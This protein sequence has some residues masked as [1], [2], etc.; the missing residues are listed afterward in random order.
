MAQAEQKG[1]PIEFD[2]LYYAK[3][4]YYY[5]IDNEIGQKEGEYIRA[6]KPALN[7]QIPKAEDWRKFDVK[8]IDEQKVLKSIL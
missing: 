4:R 7:S 8:A 3:E 1:L 2:V 6:F 5:L